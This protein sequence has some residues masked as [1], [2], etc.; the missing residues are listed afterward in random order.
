MAA[1]GPA[2]LT[3]R[4]TSFRFPPHST[5]P[6]ACA[7]LT[8]ALLCLA[9]CG[10]TRGSPD[11]LPELELGS[12]EATFEP[13]SNGSELAL[14]AG[15]QGGHHVWLSMRVRGLSGPDLQFSLDVVPSPPAPPAHTEVTL[16]FAD[17]PAGGPYEYVGWP[18]R[19]LMPECAVG[20]PVQIS[21]QLSDAQ[22]K[23]V[24]AELEVIPGPPTHGFA[25]ECRP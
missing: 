23:S 14:Y 10:D 16:H 18:A 17:A 13:A 25:V 22:G 2:D 24:E 12:G 4:P 21:V 5:A 8:L 3:V 1:Q 15:T 19:V 9:G 11:G 6:I 20:H 7:A